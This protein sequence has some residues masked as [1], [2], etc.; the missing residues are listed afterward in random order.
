LTPAQIDRLSPAAVTG[1]V[2]AV[3]TVQTE[4]HLRRFVQAAVNP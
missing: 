3:G 1:A 4:P 2:S